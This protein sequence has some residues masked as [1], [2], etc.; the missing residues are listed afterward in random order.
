MYIQKTDATIASGVITPLSSYVD[1]NTEGGASTD[2]LVTIN[3]PLDGCQLIITAVSS[4]RTVV[5]KDDTGNL[6]LSGDFT[7]NNQTDT[8]TLIG[9]GNNWLEVSRS[10]NGA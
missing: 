3:N 10:N 2:D 9:N 8:L 1:V 4:S 7:M 5:A 6:R